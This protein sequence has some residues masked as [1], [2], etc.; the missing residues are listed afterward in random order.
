MQ[1]KP[2]DLIDEVLKT[3]RA[4]SPRTKQLIRDACATLVALHD[5]Q[6]AE[7]EAK[8]LHDA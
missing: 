3:Y 2:T 5:R 6:A 8:E 4:A 1:L 7:A